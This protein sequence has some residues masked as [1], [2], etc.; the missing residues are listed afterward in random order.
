MYYN[1]LEDHWDEITI[2][3]IELYTISY[4]HDMYLYL[5]IL[6]LL[7]YLATA[8]VIALPSIQILPQ[9]RR[10]TIDQEGEMFSR[11]NVKC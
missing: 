9:K 5:S 11:I 1:D 3:D 8:A 4:L 6:L 7:N 2:R 10:M